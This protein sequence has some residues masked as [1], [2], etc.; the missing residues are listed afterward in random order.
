MGRFA[1]FR[2]KSALMTLVWPKVIRSACLKRASSPK[3][4]EI[5]DVAPK[6]VPYVKVG[7]ELKEKVNR[8]IEE[9][10]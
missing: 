2:T 8:I 1:I 7:K 10:V 3:T 9:T 5:V 6:K 4:G